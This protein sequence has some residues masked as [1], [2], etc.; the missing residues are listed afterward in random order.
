VVV[1]K[2]QNTT[3]KIKVLGVLSSSILAQK[4]QNSQ[5]YLPF[6]SDFS[7]KVE[8]YQQQKKNLQK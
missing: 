5:T 2:T 3:V 6:R 1:N 4:L 7:K 8:C